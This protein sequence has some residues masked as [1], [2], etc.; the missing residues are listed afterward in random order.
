[1]PGEFVA[2]F[3]RSRFLNPGQVWFESRETQDEL[4]IR[5]LQ[6]QLKTFEEYHEAELKAL[7]LKQRVR[8]HDYIKSCFDELKDMFADQYKFVYMQLDR[9]HE[10]YHLMK[11]QTEKYMQQNSRQERII[12]DLREAFTWEK[13][14]HDQMVNRLV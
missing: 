5:Y 6:S 3:E 4:R 12:M 10:K 2:E 9:V 7:E 13:V 1:M 8:A 14:A 11:R